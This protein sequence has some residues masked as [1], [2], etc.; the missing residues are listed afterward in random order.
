MDKDEL[1]AGL[2]GQLD[3]LKLDVN[4]SRVAEK[5]ADIE[6]L[7]SEYD[8]STD[9]LTKLTILDLVNEEIALMDRDCPYLNQPVIVTGKF[10]QSYYDDVLEKFGIEDVVLDKAVLLSHGYTV[11]EFTDD[12]GQVEKKVGHLFVTKHMPAKNDGPALVDYVTRLFAFAPV[13]TIEIEYDSND[14]DTI[15]SLEQ[16]I[17]EI[18]DEIDSLIL[19]KDNECDALMSLALHTFSNEQ[20]IPANIMS[21][22]LAY[23]DRRLDF[24]KFLPYVATIDGLVYNESNNILSIYKA[25]EG[26]GSASCVVLMPQMLALHPYPQI[27]RNDQLEFSDEGYWCLDAIIVNVDP[28]KPNTELSIPIR[29]LRDIKSVRS[30]LFVD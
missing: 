23:V 9:E 26:D 12:N 19:D 24:D 10:Q 4:L 18:I 16:I 7:I 17:P 8:E 21:K 29:N 25:E 27:G 5:A 20:D 14:K 13:G 3:N 1:N 11:L 28:N 2:F 15:H 22:L 30:M 6:K